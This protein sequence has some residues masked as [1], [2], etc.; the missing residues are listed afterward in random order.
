MLVQQSV[1]SFPDGNAR[2]WL[3]RVVAGVL[4]IRPAANSPKSPSNYFNMPCQWSIVQIK[5]STSS[6]ADGRS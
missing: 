4:R 5:Y 1:I 2:E 6:L 3:L